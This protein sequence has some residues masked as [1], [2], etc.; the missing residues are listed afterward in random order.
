MEGIQILNQFEVVT[1][2]IFSWDAFWVGLGL[3]AAIGL[4]AAIL[5]GLFAEDFEAFIAGCIF[6]VP[7]VGLLCGL[8]S[9]A[10]VAREPTAWETHYEV[11]INEEVSM[12]DFMDKYEIIETRGTIYTIKE[13]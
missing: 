5:F 11:M 4:V 2:T 3:G 9:G 12:Q 7:I 13:R 8:L 10:S 1:E 6:Y